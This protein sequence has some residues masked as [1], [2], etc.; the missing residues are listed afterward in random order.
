MIFNCLIMIYEIFLYHSLWQ[1]SVLQ[2]NPPQNT[3]RNSTSL[4][5]GRAS[6]ISDV[7]RILPDLADHLLPKKIL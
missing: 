2:K 6:G 3:K 7:P 1:Q 5:S 4:C